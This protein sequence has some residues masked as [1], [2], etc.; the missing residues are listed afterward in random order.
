MG[1]CL[2]LA[3]D[4]GTSGV[5]AVLADADKGIVASH[6]HA[7]GLSTPRPGWVEQ[8]PAM[9]QGAMAVTTRELLSECGIAAGEIAGMALTAQMFNLQPAAADGTLIGPMLSWLDQ[10]AAPQAVALAGRVPPERQFAAAGSVITAKDIV[11][12]IHWLRDEA[13]PTWRRTAWLLDCKDALL[14]WLTGRSV[15]DPAGASAYRLTD[16]AS[17]TWD[18]GLCRLLDV[19]RDLLPEV[20]TATSVA[21]GLS[22]STAATL[23]LRAGTPV[24]V[25]AGDVPASQLGSGALDDGDTHLSLGTAIYL[26]IHTAAPRADPGRRLGVLGHA[27]PR[28]WILWLEIATGG[29]ALSWI[30]RALGD[31]DRPDLPIDHAAIERL[32]DSVEGDTDHLLFAPWLSGERV[33]LFD[34]G[35]RGAFV[36]LALHHG[37]AHLV[38]AVMEGVAYQ[39]RWAYDYGLAYGVAAGSIRAVGGGGMGD[40]WLRIMADTLGRSIEVVAAPQDAAALG[41]AAMAFAGLGAWP[42]LLRVREHVRIARVVGPRPER[43]AR[44]DRG[45]SRFRALHEALRPITERLIAEGAAPV[46]AT[47]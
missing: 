36:G 18:P 3:Y 25:G 28:S 19:P 38:R 44:H 1:S 13:P 6:S 43:Q 29:A 15:T 40:A 24:F 47:Q 2:V 34:D 31:P 42:D 14:L 5:K 45:F 35:A 11:P 4:V 22:A 37:R 27:L 10:R 12:R 46:G 20:A 17:G 41:A 16:P 30:A 21:G 33:P 7:Y 32:V 9:I 39:I 23:G 8:D 26:G